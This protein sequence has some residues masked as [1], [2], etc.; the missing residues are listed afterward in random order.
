MY[1]K[2]DLSARAASQL[3]RGDAFAVIDLS[4]GWAWGYGLHD[5]YVGYVREEALGPVEE[6]SHVV[7]TS[8]ALIFAQPDIKSTVVGRWPIGAS[9]SGEPQAG[10]VGCVEG[11]LHDRHV[12]PIGEPDRD[13]VAVAERLIGAPYL[14][15]GRG[16]GGIDCSGLV[17]LALA[18]CGIA[19]PRDTDLQ[20]AAL[21]DEIDADDPLRRG[22]LIF[23]PGH[24]GMM[25]D[26]DRLLHANA[27]WMAVTV[28]PLAAVVARLGEG[29]AVISRR[30][31]VQ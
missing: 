29:E 8:Q 10:F 12:R 4:G 3:L 7:R 21:G 1:E 28:E 26:A 9:F 20:R 18:L 19:A 6:P 2:P 11:Y 23:M 22:D 27:F 5:R 14:W 24:V 16:S 15:G 13:P 31:I 25:V 17:Q 30:R